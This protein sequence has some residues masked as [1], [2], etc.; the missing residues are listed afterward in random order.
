MVSWHRRDVVILPAAAADGGR[1][2]ESGDDHSPGRQGR[3][4]DQPLAE[5]RG[6]CTHIDALED[7]SRS[8]RLRLADQSASLGCCPA[9]PAMLP[10][11]APMPEQARAPSSARS[12]D[13]GQGARL[14]RPAPRL[15]VSRHYLAVVAAEIRRSGASY[16]HLRRYRRPH[17]RIDRVLPRQESPRSGEDHSP[18]AVEAFGRLEENSGFRDLRN[19]TAWW[20]KT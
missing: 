8:C 2:S 20:L 5:T 16:G 3:S 15:S 10:A 6:G 13:H 18:D 12:H 4:S 9:A 7:S 14:N 19:S 11:I 1:S 17:R